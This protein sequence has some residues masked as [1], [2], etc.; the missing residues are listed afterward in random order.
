MGYPVDNQSSERV[1]KHQP[2]NKCIERLY[3]DELV[4]EGKRLQV[5][6][7]W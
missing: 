3:S 1:K 6:Q 4:K 7:S 2:L 5:P